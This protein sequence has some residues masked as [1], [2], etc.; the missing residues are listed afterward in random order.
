MLMRGAYLSFHRR[1]QAHFG[2]RGITADQYVVLAALAEQDD[3]TQKDLARRTYSDANTLT[4]MLN[5]LEQKG[6]V[7][8]QACDRDGRARRVH[9][10]RRGRALERILQAHAAPLHSSLEKSLPSAQRDQIGEWLKRVIREMGSAH[11]VRRGSKTASG[12]PKKRPVAN[13]AANHR[14]KNARKR[15]R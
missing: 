10:T 14:G 12:P 2:Q 13:V 6:L 5:R 3:L 1:A 4:A 15:A 11:P 9:L 7:E 8:R